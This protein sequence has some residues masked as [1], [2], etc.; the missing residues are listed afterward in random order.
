M[1]V[2]TR[3]IGW[4][5]PAQLGGLRKAYRD[6]IERLQH[7]IVQFPSDAAAIVKQRAQSLFGRFEGRGQVLPTC[8]QQQ[9][10]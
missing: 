3:Q 1:T 9:E 4:R 6:G 7:R 2:G 10:R 5:I 8:S